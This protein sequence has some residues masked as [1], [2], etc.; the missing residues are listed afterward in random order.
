MRTPIP[1]NEDTQTVRGAGYSNISY[2]RVHWPWL[3]PLVIVTILAAILLVATIV[4]SSR[5]GMNIWKSSSVAVLA[6]LQSLPR[7][8]LGKLERVTAM[9]NR[10]GGVHVILD[11]ESKGLKLVKEEK[12]DS[13]SLRDMS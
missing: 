2:V 12:S 10:A 1:D 13:I 11:G 9:E 5:R 6:A 7:S 3:V 8:E 4:V